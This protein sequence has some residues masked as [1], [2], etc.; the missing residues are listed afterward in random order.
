L[1]SDTKGGAQT[2]GVEN[3]VLRRIFGPKRNKTVE[4]RTIL[5]EELRNLYSSPNIIRMIKSRRIRWEGRIWEKNAYWSLVRNPEVK[6][7]LG[8]PRRG[9]EDNI[10]IGLG[11]NQM[12]WFELDSSAPG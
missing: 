2:E 5:H 10:K 3:S 11:R 7:S 1:V 6:K 9:W 12:G 8:R 4:G